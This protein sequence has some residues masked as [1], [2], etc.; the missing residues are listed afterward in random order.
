MTTTALADE[1][2][3]VGIFDRERQRVGDARPHSE[4]PEEDLRQ[5]EVEAI[6]AVVGSRLHDVAVLS[7]LAAT[8]GA[9]LAAL[10]YGLFQLMR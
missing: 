5:S 6:A 9:W 8:Q 3:G 1:T 4:A 10:G 7:V 2:L